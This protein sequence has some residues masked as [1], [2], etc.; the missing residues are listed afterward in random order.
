MDVTQYAA[1][2]ARLA[3]RHQV[4]WLGRFLPVG[5]EI[6]H[7]VAAGSGFPLLLIHGW[8]AWSYSWRKNIPALSKYAKVYALDLLGFGLSSKTRA[9]GYSL[10]AQAGHVL[11][12]LDAL[13]LE[14]VVLGGHSMGGEIAMRVAARAPE[15]VAGLLLVASTGYSPVTL[16]AGL[17]LALRI[18]GLAH[19]VVRATV[20]NARFARRTL[21]TAYADPSALTAADVNGYLLPGRT[22]GAIQTLVQF[23]RQMDFGQ[24][25]DCIPTLG[26]PALVI[27]GARD[28]WWPL[29]H[30]QR[31]AQEL[32]AAR[33][34]VFPGAGHVPQEEAPAAFNQV[35]QDWLAT[36]GYAGLSR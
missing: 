31:L 7:F 21:N 17:R 26:Q 2:M 10:A 8:A 27:W 23:F 1:A 13:G 35:V 22:P 19:A 28:P 20:A 5:R 4:D 6:F 18:P 33:L 11:Q 30:G 34:H 3:R 12:F 32:P 14:Q 16:P 25:V 15:R 9:A 36:L 29:A 24:A